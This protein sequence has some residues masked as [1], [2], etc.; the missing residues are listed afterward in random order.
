MIVR[1][2]FGVNWIGEGMH[3]QKKHGPRLETDSLVGH[4]RSQVFVSGGEGGRS[5]GCGMRRWT[6]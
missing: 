2:P 6:R 1:T 4:L 5:E 3:R